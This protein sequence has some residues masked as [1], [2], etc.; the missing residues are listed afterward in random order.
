MWSCGQRQLASE[1]SLS[2][3]HLHAKLSTGGS[4]EL[5]VLGILGPPFELE[6]Q[7]WI[8]CSCTSEPRRR[9]DA[10]TPT[11][12]DVA[13]SRGFQPGGDLKCSGCAKWLP[14]N[15]LWTKSQ[16]KLAGDLHARF[17]DVEYHEFK[18]LASL[19]E[20]VSTQ[21]PENGDVWT[22]GK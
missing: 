16:A 19:Y 5:D 10:E 7:F 13:L 21:V 11:V 8:I 22:S 1:G 12:D 14:K 20:F 9:D 6:Q 3:R 4:S 17:G 2:A 18:G 15:P